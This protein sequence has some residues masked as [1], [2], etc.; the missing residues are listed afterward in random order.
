MAG[1]PTA[2]TVKAMRLVLGKMTPWAAATQAGIA[3][4]TLYRSP[5]HGMWKRGELAALEE[6][7]CELEAYYRARARSRKPKKPR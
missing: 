1:K 4:V 2:R 5:L 6:K 7:L 3:P